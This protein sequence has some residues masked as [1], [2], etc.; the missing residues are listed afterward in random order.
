MPPTMGVFKFF[1]INGLMLYS[2]PPW[3]SS[4]PSPPPPLKKKFLTFYIFFSFISWT[5]TQFPSFFF[6]QLDHYSISPPITCVCTQPPFNFF[7]IFSFIGSRVTHSSTNILCVVPHF[8]LF[9]NPVL[10]QLN[11]LTALA[12][13]YSIFYLNY[14]LK[15]TGK[16]ILALL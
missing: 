8:T 1:S 10:K 16:K 15:H 4:H 6:H 3:E 7:F 9:H 5:I 12:N 14:Y 2:A 11:V 13:I